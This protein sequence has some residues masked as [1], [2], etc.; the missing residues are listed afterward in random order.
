MRF[1]DPR[2]AL[3]QRLAASFVAFAAACVGAGLAVAYLGSTFSYR[4]DL[5][6]LIHE[7]ATALVERHQ[8]G[9][10]PDLAAGISELRSAEADAAWSYVYWN[11]ADDAPAQGVAEE[12]Q[13]LALPLDLPATYFVEGR[14]LRGIVH[15]LPGGGRLSVA[16]D[17][18]AQVRVRKLLWIGALV[19][20]LLAFALVARF[21]LWA[22]SR[23]V[24]R[25]QAMNQTVTSLL[26]GNRSTRMSV[27]R[28]GDELDEL[29][30]RFN[31]LLDE[32]EQALLRVREA[33]NNI[34]HDL[35]SPLARVRHHLEAVS[36]RPDLTEDAQREVRE[37]VEEVDTLLATFQSILSIARIE[38]G[39]FRDRIGPIDLTAIALN[40]VELYEPAAE[41]GEIEFQVT[42]ESGL[43]AFGDRNLLSQ[44]ISNLIDNAIKFSRPGGKIAVSTRRTSD[45]I[46]LRVADQGPGIPPSDHRRVLER[47][48]RLD[49]ARNT[50]G[51]GLGLSLVAAVAD[52][53][54]ARLTLSDNQPGLIVTLELPSADD[55]I[56]IPV[57]DVVLTP[58][59]AATPERFE[60][61]SRSQS[62]PAVR[63]P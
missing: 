15:V 23:L 47:F 10:L 40:A 29:A 51:S 24:R 1:P 27:Q 39:A 58:K 4:A 7:R 44:A 55:A 36:R 63:E 3:R 54:A 12:L 28:P 17:V 16:R 38:S 48:T 11:A 30:S 61:G 45:G 42:T 19:G 43:H 25:L 9:G 46:E 22:S 57:R 21:G 37:A 6:Q 13:R 56:E 14:Y 31:E 5:D 60:R 32:N 26:R 20:G 34:A 50:P 49:A 33:T 62:E 53:H 52:L 8:R 41:E 35:R 59:R 18:S 2:L